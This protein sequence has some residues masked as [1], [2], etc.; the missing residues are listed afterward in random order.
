MLRNAC[1]G[2][3]E[4]FLRCMGREVQRRCDFR[5]QA[6]KWV[7]AKLQGDKTASFCKEMSV[8]KLQGDKSASQSSMELYYPWIS[9]PL[10]VSLGGKERRI[11]FSTEGSFGRGQKLKT[12]FICSNILG[13]TGISQGHTELFGPNAFMWK[14]PSPPENIGIQKFGFGFLFRA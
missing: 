14:T 1:L 3:C 7:V 10:C 2:H 11:V 5:T 8:A 6:V 12:N 4:R 9:G 13:T